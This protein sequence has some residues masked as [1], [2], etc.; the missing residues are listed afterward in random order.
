M[1]TWKETFPEREWTGEGGENPYRVAVFGN[2]FRAEV[3]WQSGYGE[4]K[5]MW[6][7]IEYSA[8]KETAQAECEAHAQDVLD[9]RALGRRYFEPRGHSTPWGGSDHAT[10][11]GDGGVVFYSTPSHGGF[12]VPASLRKGMAPEYRNDDGWYEEDC[13][14]AKVALAFPDLF[15]P[16][17][18]AAAAKTWEGWLTPEAKAKHAAMMAGM[19]G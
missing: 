8:T 16:R 19:A 11:Y 1:I 6:N 17:E 2:E 18:R 12:F 4:R 5:I 3:G 9:K 13:E 14:W 7:L 15:T 10:Q